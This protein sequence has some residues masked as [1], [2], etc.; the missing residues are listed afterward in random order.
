MNK[1][2]AGDQNTETRKNIK[3]SDSIAKNYIRRMLY[4]IEYSVFNLNT[5]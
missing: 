5:L 2:E 4:I 3:L 1:K